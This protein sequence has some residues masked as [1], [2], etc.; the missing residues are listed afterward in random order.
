MSNYNQALATSL[1]GSGRRDFYF[2]ELDHGPIGL[3]Q[4]YK[5]LFGVHTDEAAREC[6][7]L[8]GLRKRVA[9]KRRCPCSCGRRLGKCELRVRINALRIMA[10]RSWLA[11]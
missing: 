9:N 2:G 5:P 8:L 11:Q 4:D 6:V 3:A 1:R 10:P 7:Q